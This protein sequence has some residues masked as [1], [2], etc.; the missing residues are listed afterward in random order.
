MESV[1]RRQ[2]G[3]IESKNRSKENR[4][5]DVIVI[6]AGL[7]GLLSAYYLQEQGKQVLV[8]EAD[9]I[10]S[11]Q[12][13]RTTAKITSQHGLKYKNLIEKVGKRKAALYAQANEMAIREYER[14]I[15]RHNVDC[16]FKKV[17]AY[18][19]TLQN[20]EVLEEE[21]KAALA[22]GID[23][24]FTAETEL[25]FIVRGAVCFRNQGQFSPLKF[26]QYLAS[27]LT[28][29][30]HRKVIKVKGHRVITEHK[31][32]EADKIIV[33]THYPVFNLPGFYFVRQHQERSYVLAL[34]GCKRMEGMYYSID[35]NGLSLRQAGEQLLLGGSSH[36]TGKNKWGGAYDSLRKVAGEY[37]PEG[38]EE[39]HWSAQD[40]MPH[41][42]IPFIGKYSMFTPNL[43]VA[44]G[45]QKWG[46]TTAMIAAML[47]RDEVC[48]I[49]NPYRR[50]FSPQRIH[51]RASARNL[52]TD[53]EES[54]K[55]LAKGFFHKS[56]VRCSHMGCGLTWN[57]DEESWDCSCH[58]SR[59]AADGK[60]LDNPAK[61]CC[62]NCSK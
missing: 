23:A 25:P 40:C 6:G 60:L 57:P 18:L 55:G 3:K 26:V 41:D 2:T 56:P 52:F 50:L 29:L 34:S 37:F 35:K 45:F 12:T 59:F 58:G 16:D 10:A 5:W 4:Y 1:W 22:L 42:D 49:E 53:A 28:I 33:A 39:G 21:L 47:L 8:L 48:A 17:P 14:F 44:T 24:F 15:S 13:E 46:M 11:G 31:T 62:R 30:E 9:E 36:R 27:E 20:K 51:F 19:Y 43:Y 32:F 61:H 7:T 54:A 38:R